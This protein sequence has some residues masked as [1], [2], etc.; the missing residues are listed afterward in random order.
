MK[1]K[2]VNKHTAALISRSLQIDP[3]QD[4]NASVALAMHHGTWGMCS[5]SS[6]FKTLS[7]DRSSL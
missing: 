2:V 3:L 1:V 7:G 5:V 6:S 4:A